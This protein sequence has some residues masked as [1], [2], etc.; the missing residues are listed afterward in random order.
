M[1][2]NDF[3][4]HLARIFEKKYINENDYLKDLDFDS[5]IGLDITTFNDEFFPDLKIDYEKIKTS[6]TI[7]DLIKLYGNKIK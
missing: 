7:K 2:K 4:N 1:K 5:L 3:L 6:K